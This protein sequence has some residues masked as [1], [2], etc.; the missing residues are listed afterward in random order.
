MHCEPLSL[1]WN[2]S[3]LIEAELDHTSKRESVPHYL[4]Y[5][6]TNLQK[7][8][9][10]K[11]FVSRVETELYK[12]VSRLGRFLGDGL[13]FSYLWNGISSQILG[14]RLWIFPK[15]KCNVCRS[16]GRNPCPGLSPDAFVALIPISLFDQ[17]SGFPENCLTVSTFEISYLLRF[18]E[19]GYAC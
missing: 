11:V 7:F 6:C 19:M 16:L 10:Q 2:V 14:V 12:S 1:V 18:W 5:K 8:L 9:S 15:S 3:E 13:T 17:F 4:F